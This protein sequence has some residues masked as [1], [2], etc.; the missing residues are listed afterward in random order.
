[1]KRC[2]SAL[3]RAGLLW[4]GLAGAAWAGPGT[5]AVLYF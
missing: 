3:F 2:I 1:M 4:G 5:V